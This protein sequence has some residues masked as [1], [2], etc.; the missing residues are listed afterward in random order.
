MII[1]S[2]LYWAFAILLQGNGVIS[3]STDVI[4]CIVRRPLSWP[5]SHIVVVLEVATVVA[6]KGH[7]VFSE[8]M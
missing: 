6:V 5:R 2:A 8:N 4:W 7:V 1:G 3:Y